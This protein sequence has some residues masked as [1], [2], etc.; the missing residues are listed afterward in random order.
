M[1]SGLLSAYR[2]TLSATWLWSRPAAGRT[3]SGSG[4]RSYGKAATNVTREL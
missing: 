3:A 4:W 2:T 1:S